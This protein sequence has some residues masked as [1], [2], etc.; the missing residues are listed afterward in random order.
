VIHTLKPNCYRFT[1]P[2]NIAL[3]EELKVFTAE[4]CNARQSALLN[5]YVGTVEME[6]SCMIDMINQHIIPSCKR[7]E[8]GPIAELEQTVKVLQDSLKAIHHESDEKKKADLARSIRL[9]TMISARDV[10]DAAEAVVPA[11]EWTLATYKELLF[12]DQHNM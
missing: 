4:E 1:E 5:H 3:F 10:C 8:V 9:E 11:H 12:L 6:L 7:G 2:K